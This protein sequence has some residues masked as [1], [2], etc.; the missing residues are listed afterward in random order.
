MA[1]SFH[2]SFNEHFCTQLGFRLSETFYNSG[3][4]ELKGFWCD[5]VSWAPYYRDE[6]NKE[7]V[8]ES[9]VLEEREIKTTC[10]MGPTGQEVY[11]L[12]IRFWPAFP[13]CFFR[14]S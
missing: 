8:A 3:G 7:L 2:P 1:D 11:E 12:T 9:R 4:P 5:G 13:G 14:G 10:W 6:H